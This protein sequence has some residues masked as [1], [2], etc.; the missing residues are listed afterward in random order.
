MAVATSTAIALGLA[1]VGT[2]TTLYAQ[3][4]QAKQAES[5]AK[6][7]AEQAAADAAA[8]QGDALVE[9]NR[10]RTAAKAQRSQAVAALAASGVDVNSPTALKI[11]SEIAKNAEEDALLTIMGGGDRAARLNQQSVAD[12]GAARSARSA[13]RAAQA[14]TLLSAGTTMSV[15]WK[16]A[17]NGNATWG[18]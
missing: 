10:I 2:A 4:T 1:A 18:G 11:D 3:D 12:L 8:M 16:R 17:S 6:F 14:A 7:Q 5:N 9:A 15:G 13:G